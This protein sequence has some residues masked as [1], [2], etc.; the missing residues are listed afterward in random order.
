MLCDVRVGRE[1]LSLAEQGQKA[2][3]KHKFGCIFKIQ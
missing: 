1:S 3:L 2:I